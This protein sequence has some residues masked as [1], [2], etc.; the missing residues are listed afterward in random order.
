MSKNRNKRQRGQVMESMDSK[1]DFW[2]GF[3][4]KI[5]YMYECMYV[6]LERGEGKKSAREK[7]TDV[8]VKHQSIASRMHPTRD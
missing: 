6:F 4:F 5:L 1:P 7:N 3:F 8:K 2:V